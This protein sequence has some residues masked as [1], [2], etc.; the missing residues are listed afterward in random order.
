MRRAIALLAFA[1]LSGCVSLCDGIPPNYCAAHQLP[2]SEQVE[3][4]KRLPADEQVAFYLFMMDKMRPPNLELAYAIA[5]GDEKV[6][7]YATSR[8]AIEKD[9]FRINNILYVVTV[10]ANQL[11]L[12][13]KLRVQVIEMKN[14]LRTSI[15]SPIDVARFEG[16]MSALSVRKVQ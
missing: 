16:Y 2:L 4:Q 7:E 15:K 6:F 12:S 13:E 1:L 10:R 8:L 14:S 5:L 9:E 11:M 3:F